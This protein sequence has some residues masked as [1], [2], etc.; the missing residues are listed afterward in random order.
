MGMRQ[1]RDDEDEPAVIE[2]GIAAL[3]ARLSEAEV[4][5]PADAGTVLRAAG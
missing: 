3:D 1:P 2:F 5:F 4:T